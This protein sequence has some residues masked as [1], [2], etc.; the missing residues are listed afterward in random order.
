MNIAFLPG[1]P[2]YPEVCNPAV[3]QE[4]WT[5][6]FFTVQV[7][8]CSN[9]S[10]LLFL[11]VPGDSARDQ[12]RAVPPK[13]FCISLPWLPQL[14]RQHITTVA[15]TKRSLS[16]RPSYLSLHNHI[17]EDAR[18]SFSTRDLSTKRLSKLG[19]ISKHSDPV[20]IHA[21]SL[22][23]VL[24]SSFNSLSYMQGESIHR[25]FICTYFPHPSLS[26]PSVFNYN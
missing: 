22:K 23:S 14:T 18:Y 4:L 26:W 17:S 15:D 11:W 2:C 20:H 12:S 5:K 3:H 1:V 8:I 16:Y 13:Y 25:N 21:V 10:R 19:L 6:G 9:I 24:I 7:H